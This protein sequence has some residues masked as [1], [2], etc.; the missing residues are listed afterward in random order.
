MAEER[1][2]T[3]PLRKDFLKAPKYKRT[4][5]AVRSLR[6]F[7]KRHMKS[8]DIK[9]GKYLNKEI[10]KHGKK[11]PPGKVQVKVIKDGNVVKAELINAPIE[12]EKRKE[13]KGKE[14]KEEKVI[15]SAEKKEKKEILEKGTQ[16][17]ERKV[18]MDAEQKT[19]DKI[20]HES[21]D[22]KQEQQKF[23]SQKIITK[24]QKPTHEKSKS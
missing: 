7:L 18:L 19:T 17:E 22:T 20:K 21:M 3:I 23:R 15:E 24:T 13:E 9:I 11:N 5:R 6:D 8:D 14:I 2:Y 4:A 10:W 16:K 12:K 1:I